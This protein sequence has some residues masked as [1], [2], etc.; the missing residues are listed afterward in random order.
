MVQ[1]RFARLALGAL[2]GGGAVFLIAIVA[3]YLYQIPQFKGTYA[4]GVAFVWMPL[5]AA[6][7]ALFA[8]MMAK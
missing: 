4:M 3:S 6:A 1:T 5:G 8:R 7:G 2:I